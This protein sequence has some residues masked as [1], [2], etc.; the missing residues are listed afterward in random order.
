MQT[1][2][3]GKLRA[4][5]C[6]CAVFVLSAA[7]LIIFLCFPPEPD[8]SPILGARDE[9]RVEKGAPA[10]AGTPT[11]LSREALLQGKLLLVSPASPLP[12]DFAPPS[13]RDIRA[14]VGSY[15]PALEGVMLCQEAVYALCTMQFEYPLEG[16]ISMIRGAL[17]NAQQEEWRREA[18]DRYS[19]VYPLNEAM[20]RVIAEIPGG[21]ESEHQTGYALDIAM[22]GPLSL[23]GADPLLHNTA[24]RWLQ[25]NMWRFGWIYRFSPRE[26]S[27]GSCEGIHLRYVGKTHASAMHALNLGLEEY[28]SLLREQKSVTLL[29]EQSPYA[30]LYCLPCPGDLSIPLPPD[31]AWEA[32]A[33]NTGWAVIAVAAQ[34]VF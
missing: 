13:T 5:I 9:W 31:G 7:G 26:A 34:G 18:F 22:K 29:R 28:L 3:L 4:G 20:N 24:G 19:R 10:L 2:E 12:M 25:E 15:L 21:G 11:F 23:V 33:D 14:M 1:A 8:I 6:A 17:S 16:G 30:Y 32:S 27:E